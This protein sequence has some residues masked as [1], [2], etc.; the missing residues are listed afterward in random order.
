[1]QGMDLES[2]FLAALAG[3]KR[4]EVEGEELRLYGDSGLVLRFRA[5]SPK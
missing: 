2:A 1:M 5:S 4:F 3:S